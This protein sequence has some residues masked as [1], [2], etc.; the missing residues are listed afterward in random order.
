MNTSKTTHHFCTFSDVAVDGAGVTGGVVG[1][2]ELTVSTV[3]VLV[4]HLHPV[5]CHGVPCQLTD[6]L[7]ISKE[8]CI[9]TEGD[10][11]CGRRKSIHLDN[12]NISYFI[13][14]YLSSFS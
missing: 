11:S 9:S 14:S 3:C 7:V 13:H 12:K 10:A 6:H 8:V 5:G 1:Q 2:V 4:H